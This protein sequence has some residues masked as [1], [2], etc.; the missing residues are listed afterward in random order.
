[1]N[2]ATG[3]RSSIA[4]DAANGTARRITQIRSGTP[5]RPSKAKAETLAIARPKKTV[6]NCTA[7]YAWILDGDAGLR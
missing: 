6:G 2:L 7:W 4:S 1:M 5:A 3:T